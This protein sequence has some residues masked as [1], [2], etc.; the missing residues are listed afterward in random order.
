M[1]TSYME[2]IRM[3]LGESLER[4]PRVF[5]YGQDIAGSFGGAFK[6]TKG[7]AERFPGRV[8]NAPIS[9]D[10]IAGVGIG[11]AI[12]GMRPVIEYQFADFASL[13][14][15]QLVNQAATVHWRTGH[16]CPL[17]VRL[18]VGGTRGS[19]PFHCQ[20]PEAW[21]C[22]HP[23]LVVV[24][25]ATV[26]DA[27]WMLRDAIACDDP[28]VFCEHKY[29]YSHLRETG[30]PRQAEHL[31][32]GRAA[33][34]QSGRDCT[35]ISYS[36]MVHEC[37]AAAGILAS[38]HGLAIEVVDLRCLRPLDTDTLLESVAKTG[39]V[40]VVSEAWPFGGIPAEVVAT[41][42]GSVFHLLDAPPVRICAHD[43]PIPMHPGLYA[44]HRPNAASI[45]AAVLE[46]V[47]F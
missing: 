44:A 34:R 23:G 38:E 43:T 46:T 10:A 36:G 47:R 41:I 18:P 7:L 9:E 3:A 6:V 1:T 27:Y 2:A 13:G 19:G 40:V 30:D 8:I 25:P 28:V 5:I 24:A 42:T 33:L 37:L 20:M 12:D 16:S 21:L 15:N 31:P 11:A 26:P 14:F 22:H 39:R 17:V 35:I 32:L 4:D 45:V 29:L